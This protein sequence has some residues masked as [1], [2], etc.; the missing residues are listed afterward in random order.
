L[1]GAPLTNFTGYVSDVKKARAFDIR[2]EHVWWIVNT[3]WLSLIN[4]VGKVFKS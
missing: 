4:K 2:E 3:L 1:I